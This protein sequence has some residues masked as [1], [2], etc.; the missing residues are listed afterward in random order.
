MCLPNG[1]FSLA[2]SC[3]VDLLSLCAGVTPN[4]SQKT[5]KITH[6]SA[7]AGLQTDPNGR[8]FTAFEENRLAF[9]LW[10]AEPG[11]CKHS[12]RREQG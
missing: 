1:F 10:L 11:V 4:T 2:E 3:E 9:D 12:N 6:G 7:R 5:G 8:R